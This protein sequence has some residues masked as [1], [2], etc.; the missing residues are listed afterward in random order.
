MPRKLGQNASEDA[1]PF[2]SQTTNEHPTH[3]VRDEASGDLHLLSLSAAP[4]LA[5]LPLGT[6]QAGGPL[7]WEKE[8]HS[9]IVC[10]GR[11]NYLPVSSAGL[12][13]VPENL[14]R[15]EPVVPRCR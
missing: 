13:L 7:E 1:F 10:A 15:K 11:R 8:M 14:R 2:L 12:M 3:T 9:E 6:G 5:L 4:F